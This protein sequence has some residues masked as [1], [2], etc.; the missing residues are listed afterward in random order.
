[1]SQFVFSS[2]L[3]GGA[4]IGLS[5]VFLLLFKGRIAGISGI[6]TSV[7][8]SNHQEF[9]WRALFLIGLILGPVIAVYFGSSLPT[10][11]D[12]SWPVMII[13]GFL[14]GFGSNLGNGCTSGHGICGVGRFSKR[15]IVA[16]A[17]FMSI[18]ILTVFVIGFFGASSI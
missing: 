3:I 2:A 16:T 11:I 13:G 5:A 18:A 1:M 10:S 12:A 15:S 4:I 9:T 14:V 7:F 6:L 8:S 17:T